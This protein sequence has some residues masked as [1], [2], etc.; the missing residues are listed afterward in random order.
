[1]A[2]APRIRCPA[3]EVP[4]MF[5]LVSDSG[6]FCDG[7][8]RRSF[9]SIGS[10]AMGGLTLPQLL[11]AEDRAGIGKSHKS[12]IMVYL[13]G[14]LAHQDTFDLKPDAPKEVRGEFN[15]IETN[16]AG[17]QICEL[18]PKMAGV[19]DKIAL[20]R[21]L[22]GQR[23]EHTSFQNLTGFPMNE[24]LREGKP[25]L[26]CVVSRVQGPTDPLVPPF[27]DLF[28]VMQHKPYN[29]PGPGML[30][31]RFGSV[32]ADGEDLASMKL[33]YVSP[34]R[35]EDRKRLLA[36]VDQFRRN[37]EATDLSRADSMYERA[38]DVLTTSKLVEA[39]DIEK[40]D[41]ALRERY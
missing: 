21:S 26:G 20:V 25:N 37:V 18:L 36:D 10:L 13:S 23:D 7:L 4:A 1:M 27:V 19:M 38:F 35:L 11:R 3:F 5:T 24:S 16:V 6:R 40:E 31:T 33:R 2:A 30:G 34:A 29:S 39:L 14:G 8:S 22:V 15:P 32:T 12:V 17:T 28:P 41:P 9:L